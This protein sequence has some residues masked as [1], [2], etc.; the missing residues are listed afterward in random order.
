VSN[1]SN[2]P[3]HLTV[4][5]IETLLA[6]YKQPMNTVCVV[7]WLISCQID[8][9]KAM[10][11]F[12]LRDIQVLKLIG[13]NELEALQWVH[14]MLND[15]DPFKTVWLGWADDPASDILNQVED[16]RSRIFEGAAR[17]DKIGSDLA[18]R[19]TLSMRRRRLV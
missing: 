2:S 3:E 19:L 15:L 14:C 10:E 6:A 12:N 1:I 17:C 13:L 5:Q 11:A 9:A 7:K 8:L 18:T 16:L 4:R